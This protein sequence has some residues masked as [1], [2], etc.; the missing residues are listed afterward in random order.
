MVDGGVGVSIFTATQIILNK[1]QSR[2][3]LIV[4]CFLNIFPINGFDFFNIHFKQT[5][6]TPTVCTRVNFFN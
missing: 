5:A 2:Y 4:L 1:L 6:L 3:K